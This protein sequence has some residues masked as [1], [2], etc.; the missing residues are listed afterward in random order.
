MGII[1]LYLFREGLILIYLIYRFGKQLYIFSISFD[2]FMTR[3]PTVSPK[4]FTTIDLTGYIL[5]VLLNAMM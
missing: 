2:D 3:D 1:I 5:I 4:Y